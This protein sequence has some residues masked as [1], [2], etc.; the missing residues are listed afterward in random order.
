MHYYL[1]LEIERLRFHI[2]ALYPIQEVN[3]API[4]QYVLTKQV[5]AAPLFNIDADTY[6]VAHG[7]MKEDLD[8]ISFHID[9][10]VTHNHLKINFKTTPHTDKPAHDKV[11]FTKVDAAPIECTQ[12]PKRPDIALSLKSGKEGAFKLDLNLEDA[13]GNITHS[14]QLL[15]HIVPNT[16]IWDIALDFGSEA[17]QLS[18]H[19]ASSGGTVTSVQ[20]I[21]YLVSSF[22]KH[23]EKVK[24]EDFMQYDRDG[25]FRSVFLAASEGVLRQTD[26]PNTDRELVPMLTL[27][28]L[29]DE[30]KT[31]KYKLLPTVK[32]ATFGIGGSEIVTVNG[33][34]EMLS[35]LVGKIHRK[36]IFNFL[37]TACKSI[38]ANADRYIRFKLLIPNVFN[39]TK[40]KELVEKMERDVVYFIKD[41]PE[42]KLKG[43]EISTMSESDAAFAGY[44]APVTAPLKANGKY[45]IIDAGRGTTDYS[46]VELTAA[47]EAIGLYRSGFI[48]AGAL[49]TFAF[50]DT[51]VMHLLKEHYN[52][53]L[54][55]EL[56]QV[57]RVEFFKKVI[58]EADAKWQ[59]A[60]FQS[61]ELLK[62]GYGRHIQEKGVLIPEVVD[63]EK[64]PDLMKVDLNT[65]NNW[66][67]E[68]FLKKP[69]RS[70]ADSFGFIQK[71]TDALVSHLLTDIQNIP[72]AF[73]QIDKLDGIILSGRGFLFKPLVAALKA[74]F[75]E[76]VVLA[77]NLKNICIQGAFTNHR[78][79]GNCN[80]IGIPYAA[81]TRDDGKQVI[82]HQP[83]TPLQ[84]I[85]T[86]K[87]WWDWLP[88]WGENGKSAAPARSKQGKDNYFRDME[89]FLKGYGDTHFNATTEAIFVSGQEYEQQLPATN[90][91]VNL[92]FT[93]RDFLIRSETHVETLTPVP[94]LATSTEKGFA[95]KTLFPA[96][97]AKGE[98][99]LDKIPDNNPL[100]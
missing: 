58:C 38:T 70:M 6:F 69:N 19:R 62:Q 32:L 3:P 35:N 26:P 75:G 66:L 53:V 21:P 11:P 52:K 46:I 29:M 16:N 45:L 31:K 89:G 84:P 90:G 100:M 41:F 8:W 99:P 18:V 37:H 71:T 9:F 36:L 81:I 98:V 79:N 91:L 50:L 77:E 4:K 92:F 13:T 51:L 23:Y 12:H 7:G 25:L 96:L 15:L 73:A 61:V 57:D 2:A 76:K 68:G 5:G 49:L 55:K 24:E 93:G 72:N 65:L 17:S 47:K 88:S 33:Q 44:R 48:G 1:P 85:K 10:D 83:L 30:L 28:S 56:S 78:F 86:A 60:F 14:S 97:N 74:R 54:K 59:T 40:I 42:Y 43:V 95:A 63:G 67:K 64:V 22:Y 94:T 87:S 39:Q 80:M 27:Q 34:T 82:Q 20:M